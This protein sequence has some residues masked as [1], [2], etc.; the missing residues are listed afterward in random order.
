MIHNVPG[1]QRKFIL[2]APGCRTNQAE[3]EA[4]ASQMEA[5][6]WTRTS[7]LGEADLALVAGCVVTARAERDT[8]RFLHRSRRDAPRLKAAL[9]GCLAERLALHPDPAYAP[10]LIVRLKERSLLPELVES[11]FGSVPVV[12]GEGMADSGFFFVPTFKTQDKSRYFFKIQ[13]GCDAGCTYCLVRQVRGPLASLPLP[14]I[15]AHLQ[16]LL[17]HGV[18][19]VVFCGTRLGRY[20]GDLGDGSSLI[21]LAQALEGMEGEFRWRLSS[22][23]PWDIP[24]AFLD[25]LQECPRFCRFFH[26]P[27]QSGSDA[28]LKRMNRPY[29]AQDYRARIESIRARFPGARIGTDV[30]TGFP[31]EDAE[32]FHETQRFLRNCRVDYL[33]IFSFSRRPGL[34]R[35]SPEVPPGQIKARRKALLRL[36]A[37]KREEDRSRRLG[38]RVSALSI[39]THGFLEDNLF[40]RFEDPRP[41]GVFVPCTITGWDGAT[42]R[43][44][45]EV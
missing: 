40:C 1:C 26:I 8:R 43:V 6:G 4:Y 16:A 41:A 27:V 13:D 34:P 10:D 18:K 23:E 7:D 24:E 39:G 33:H 9:L 2:F 31:G 22:I 20:G 37:Q 28:V 11:L 35:L 12:S 25:T 38:G 17:R 36:D 32:E 29:R 21:R 5:A 42:A 19:E 14:R 30:M 3:G 45:I 15:L 44:K